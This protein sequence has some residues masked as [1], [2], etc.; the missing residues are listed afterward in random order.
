[1]DSAAV[2]ISGYGL[3]GRD[4]AGAFAKQQAPVDDADVGD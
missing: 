1:M 3:I 4:K 2:G